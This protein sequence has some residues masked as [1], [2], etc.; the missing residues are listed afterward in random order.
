MF[1]VGS[2]SFS[3]IISHKYWDTYIALKHGAEVLVLVLVLIIS[4]A[5]KTSPD[6]TRQPELNTT[7][8]IRTNAPA[9]E[10]TPLV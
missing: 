8:R 6:R 3:V 7:R 5:I 10:T 4:A 2:Q 1:I 9:T